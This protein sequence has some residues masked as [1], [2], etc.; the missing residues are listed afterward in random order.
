MTVPVGCLSFRRHAFHAAL[1][2]G[3]GDLHRVLAAAEP[4]VA[5]RLHAC[6]EALAY[7]VES[8]ELFAGVA[9]VA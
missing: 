8:R 9:T 2:L 1:A 7:F 3:Q 4:L 6:V 5:A